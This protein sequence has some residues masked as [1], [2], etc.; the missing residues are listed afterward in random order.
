MKVPMVS[1]VSVTLKEK[2]VIRTS[3]SFAI[4]VKRLGR[5]SAVKIAPK[6]EGSALQASIKLTVSVVEVTPIGIPMIAVAMM[7]ISTAP[8]TFKTSS[9]TVR[10]RPIRKSQKAGWLRVARAG[11]PEPKVIM[12]TFRRPR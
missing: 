12:P 9:T 6:V 11:T 10:A 2:M 5:P 1:K 7:P 4:S 3:G 8:L